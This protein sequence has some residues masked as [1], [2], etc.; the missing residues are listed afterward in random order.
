MAQL[1]AFIT[2]LMGHTYLWPM[3]IYLGGAGIPLFP[4][5]IIFFLLGAS[6]A[7]VTLVMACMIALALGESSLCFMA[8]KLGPKIYRHGPLALFIKP[9]KL[10][11]ARRLIHRYGIYT[12]LATR[13][14]PGT[15]AAVFLSV[16]M[17]RY[18]L[19]QVFLLSLISQCLWVPLLYFSGKLLWI[20]LH[21]LKQLLASVAPIGVAALA[22]LAVCGLL[23]RHFRKP[24]E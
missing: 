4:S 21:D 1:Q 2:D 14:L 11:R 6:N 22:I 13:F 24:R 5:D 15:R 18:P 9:V 3:A 8:R 23:N 20:E 17:L 19:R 12:L 16:G 10:L 7:K